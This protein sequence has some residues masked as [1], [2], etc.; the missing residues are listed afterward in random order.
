[1]T[2]EQPLEWFGKRSARKREADAGI[3][4]AVAS[5]AEVKLNLIADVK[6]AFYDLLVAQRALELARQNQEIV[7]DSGSIREGEG[8]IGG[9]AGV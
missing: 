2:L 6:I 7:G 1:M 8:E 9:G 3:G 4:G 5:L